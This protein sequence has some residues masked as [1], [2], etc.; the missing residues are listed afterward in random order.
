MRNNVTFATFVVSTLVIVNALNTP[1]FAQENIGSVFAA[2]KRF[3]NEALSLQKQCQ[4]LT[5]DC[6]EKIQKLDAD[7]KTYYNSLL[8]KQVSVI[9]EVVSSFDRAVSCLSSDGPIVV[10]SG[11]KFFPKDKIAV[12]GPIAVIGDCLGEIAYKSGLIMNGC[13]ANARLFVGIADSYNGY[14]GPMTIKLIK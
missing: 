3:Q 12:N 6:N 8:Q 1:S 10:Y 7:R 14:L 5:R 9:C 2:V 13:D 11:D 4:T